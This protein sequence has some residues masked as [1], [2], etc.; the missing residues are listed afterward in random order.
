MMIRAVTARWSRAATLRMTSWSCPSATGMAVWGESPCT[1]TAR[2]TAASCGTSSRPPRAASASGGPRRSE[3]PPRQPVPAHIPELPGTAWTGQGALDDRFRAG[4]TAR[5]GPLARGVLRP[6][7]CACLQVRL[8]PRDL[9]WTAPGMLG[10]LLGDLGPAVGAAGVLVLVDPRPAADAVAEA[11]DLRPVALT[12]PGKVQNGPYPPIGPVVLHPFPVITLGHRGELVL[13]QPEVIAN[14]MD[15][16]LHEQRRGALS[17]ADLALHPVDRPQRD[18]RV[19]RRQQRPHVVARHVHF[20]DHAVRV[21]AVIRLRHNPH[22]LV[23][24]EPARAVLQAVEVPVVPF[25]GDDDPRLVGR[26][27]VRRG[28]VDRHHN[29]PPLREGVLAGEHAGL[30][31]LVDREQRPGRV[32]QEQALEFL[33]QHDRV[34]GVLALDAFPRDPGEVDVLRRGRLGEVD[35]GTG[36]AVLALELVPGV[37]DELADQPDALRR[38]SDHQPGPLALAEG[39]HQALMIELKITDTGQLIEPDLRQV[40]AP[41]GVRFLGGEAADLG[42]VKKFKLLQIL[43]VGGYFDTTALSFRQYAR[44]ALDAN[45][46]NVVVPGAADAD[47]DVRLGQGHLDRPRGPRTSFTGVMRPKALRCVVFGSRYVHVVE[48]ARPGRLDAGDQR[49]LVLHRPQQVP[50]P[51]VCDLLPAARRQETMLVGHRDDLVVLGRHREQIG[52]A[53][54]ERRPFRPGGRRAA[55]SERQDRDGLAL[56]REDVYPLVTVLNRQVDQGVPGD[57]SAARE[58]EPDRPQGI[59]RTWRAL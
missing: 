10:G 49:P 56:G 34:A 59:T 28:R 48:Q 45:G 19:H 43:V 41:D 6:A 46:A 23:R 9:S 3:P 17:P 11:V 2:I 54:E 14:V 20:A 39:G 8:G 40:L 29:A 47:V 15:A 42:A 51:Q 37:L 22:L 26:V 21:M 25:G 18:V 35:A 53:L 32:G 52:G 30:V 1:W 44:F 5:T 13:Q 7:F 38:G 33:L 57:A 31:E 12:G 36:P 16:P 55:V 58:V 4:S 50:G 27:L 24:G